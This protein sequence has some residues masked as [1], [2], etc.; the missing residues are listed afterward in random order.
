MIE[1]V[2]WVTEDGDIKGHSMMSSL[3][4]LKNNAVRDKNIVSSWKEEITFCSTLSLPAPTFSFLCSIFF[5]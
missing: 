3:G 2:G 4:V 5:L 1:W